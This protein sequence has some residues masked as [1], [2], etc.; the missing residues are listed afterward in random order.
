[1]PRTN[2]LRDNESIQESNGVPVKHTPSFIALGTSV[3]ESTWLHDFIS[4]RGG[5][6]CVLVWWMATDHGLYRIETEA[7]QFSSSS[8]IPCLLDASPNI[9]TL[10]M[11]R[12]SQRLFTYFKTSYTQNE[13]V[14]PNQFDIIDLHDIWHR[15]A[16]DLPW[17]DTTDAIEGLHSHHVHCVM[18]CGIP[19]DWRSRVAA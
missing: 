18:H 5:R 1:M 3:L 10:Q 7:G 13:S 12:R 17:F 2:R 4:G 11:K 14:V 16:W 15:G 8:D 9:Q 19:W 6:A